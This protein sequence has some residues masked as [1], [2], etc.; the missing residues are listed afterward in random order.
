MALQ[1]KESLYV[2][3]TM[4]MVVSKRGKQEGLA[5]TGHEYITLSTMCHTM[6]M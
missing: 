5:E 2:G 4:E 3:F 6:T 1:L